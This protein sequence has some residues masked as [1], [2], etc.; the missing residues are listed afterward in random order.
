MAEV[1]Y[2]GSF[3]PVT[4]GHLDLVRRADALFGCLVVA[5]ARNPKKQE[6]F[7]IQ[8]RVEMLREETR[9]MKTVEVVS[10]EGLVVD[11]CR[12]EGIRFMLR[13]IR[14]VSDFEFEYQLALTNRHL[15]EK[16]ETVFMVP[17]AKYGY[18]SSSL[19]RDVMANGGDV[20]AW[21]SPAVEERLRRKFE[22]HRG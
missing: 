2:P 3:D 10:F 20:S 6:F 13:G 22:G 5:V 15:S 14:S 17:N 19:I 8:E 4:Y 21:I 18:I 16:L 9:E 7:S 1:V 12:K 11:F